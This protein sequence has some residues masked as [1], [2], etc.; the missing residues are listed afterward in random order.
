MMTNDINN[1]EFNDILVTNNFY[2]TD[3]GYYQHTKYKIKLDYDKCTGTVTINAELPLTYTTSELSMNVYK[4]GD[5]KSDTE[6]FYDKLS[7]SLDTVIEVCY[8]YDKK[9]EDKTKEKEVD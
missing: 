4:D 3:L 8:V 6:A 7:E 9:A 1:T 2:N 5:S